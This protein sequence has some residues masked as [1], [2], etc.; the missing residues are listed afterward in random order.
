MLQTSLCSALELVINQALKYDL[1]TQAQLQSIDGVRFQFIVN[2]PSLSISLLVMGNEVMIMA[3]DA[4]IADCIIEGTAKDFVGVA[5]AKDKN[6]ALID[7]P[8]NI[9]GDTRQF[10]VLQQVFS[11]IDIDWEAFIA[12]HLGDVAGHMVAD[13]L[14][15]MGGL[16]KQSFDA[17]KEVVK[18][19][20][21][22]GE[23]LA[24]P[25]DIE[26]FAEKVNELKFDSERLDAK[27][28]QFRQKS[29]L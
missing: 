26:M 9:S 19:H 28:R 14:R 10:M 13:G 4:A 2:S 17:K 8:L 16:F 27:F 23:L 11:D 24:K 5:K 20:L 15:F 21:E 12:D 22:S 29:G 7:H 3:N 6:Q 1:K 18:T 25:I